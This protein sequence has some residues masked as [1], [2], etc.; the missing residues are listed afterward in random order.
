MHFKDP[1]L[2]RTVTWSICRWIK[3]PINSQAIIRFRYSFVIFDSVQ[4][5]I[6]QMLET[7]PPL[8]ELLWLKINE[9]KYTFLSNILRILSQN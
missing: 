3:G 5:Q 8:F 6:K 2:F 1:P 7:K 9:M 4:N